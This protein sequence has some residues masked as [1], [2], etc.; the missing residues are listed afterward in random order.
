[1]DSTAR[2]RSAGTATRTSP[3]VAAAAR[4]ALPLTPVPAL[5]LPF[6]RVVAA[7]SADARRA[8]ELPAAEREFYAATA[9]LPRDAEPRPAEC[10]CR[11]RGSA[12]AR[13][14]AAAAVLKEFLPGPGE[15]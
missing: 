11:Q 6:T 10:L 1:M 12:A 2:S 8:T 4:A 14:R 9:L 7:L 15:K 5:L 3:A 13:T